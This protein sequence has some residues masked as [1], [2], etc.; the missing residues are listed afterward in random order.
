[1]HFYFKNIKKI[2][3]S[4]KNKNFCEDDLYCY[5]K[6][7]IHENLD[8]NKKIFAGYCSNINWYLNNK[9][10]NLSLIDDETLSDDILDRILG[11]IYDNLLN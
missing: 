10:F 11:N 1:M 4:K 2:P 5:E 9:D 6:L 7:E 8:T 3:K